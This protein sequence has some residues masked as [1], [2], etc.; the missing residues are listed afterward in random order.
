MQLLPDHKAQGRHFGIYP[1]E[2]RWMWFFTAATVPGTVQ[3]IGNYRGAILLGSHSHSFPR[4]LRTS[5]RISLSL[6]RLVPIVHRAPI[7]IPSSPIKSHLVLQASAWLYAR[8]RK[9]SNYKE[10]TGVVCVVGIETFER[11]LPLFDGRL[12]NMRIPIPCKVIDIP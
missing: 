9:W 4:Y 6:H 11:I 8:E 1:R 5:R 7:Y 12:S 3:L 10:I 2:Q